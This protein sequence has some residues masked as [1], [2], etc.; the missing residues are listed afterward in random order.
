MRV[1]VWARAR[2]GKLKILHAPDRLNNE[3]GLFEQ[4]AFTCQRDTNEMLP[5]WVENEKKKI[6]KNACRYFSLVRK[7]ISVT[8]GCIRFWKETMNHFFVETTI[9]ISVTLPVVR[10][11]VVGGPR[12][13]NRYIINTSYFYK[14]PCLYEKMQIW[15]ALFTF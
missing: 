7:Y 13:N 8:V 6:N 15:S 5:V 10:G 1:C 11:L 4:S 2:A 3:C 12:N 9:Y 14:F